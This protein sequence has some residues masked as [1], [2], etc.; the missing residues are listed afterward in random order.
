VLPTAL[1]S[2]ATVWGYDL[3]HA[4]STRHGFVGAVFSL[5]RAFRNYG[6]VFGLGLFGG[7]AYPLTAGRE[8]SLEPRRK[9][10][11][12]ERGSTQ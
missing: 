3:V 1:H 9:F 12:T 8:S 5:S 11:Y 4:P 6:D 2:F 7:L 10:G